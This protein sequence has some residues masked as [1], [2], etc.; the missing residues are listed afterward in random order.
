MSA[1]AMMADRASFGQWLK[2]RRKALD[3]TREELAQKIGCAANTIYK[4]EADERRPS[5]QIAAL[6]AEHLNIP[7]DE[8]AAFIQFARGETDEAAV[9][10]GTPFHPPT[11]LP[12]PPTLLIGRDEDVAA[13]RKRLVREESRLLTLIGPP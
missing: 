12:A 2:Q 8:R 4:I 13:V 7:P 5:Q 1:E 6:L 9:P 11:N 3:L 10:W